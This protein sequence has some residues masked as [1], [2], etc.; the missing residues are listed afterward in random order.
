MLKP[1][2][3]KH[4]T[5]IR[6]LACVVVVL[7]V[8]SLQASPALAQPLQKIVAMVGARSG[9]SWP[10]WLAKDG[11]YYRKH[12]LDVELVF[13][14]HPAPMAAVISGQAVMTST[15]ADLAILAASKDP[16]LTLNGSFLNRG[17]FAM[18]AAKNVT[19]MEQLA[20]KK[21]GVGRVGDPPYH[22]TVSLLEKFGVSGR[23]IHW[24]SVGAD[25]ATRAAALQGG[26]IDAALVTA[27]SYFRLEAAGYPVLALISDYEDIYVSTY[28]LFRKDQVINSPKIAEGFIKAHAEAIK[29]FYDDRAFA[30]QT[31]LKYGG[32]RDQQDGNKVYDLFS[33]SRSFEPVPYILKD[34]VRAAVERQSQVLPQL[35]QFDFTKVIDNSIV[36]R[37]VREGFF[38]QVFGP[39]VREL[40][41]K[42]QAQAF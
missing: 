5:S 33:K 19:R 17:T 8:F 15:G 42:R 14:V 13:A 25:A 18:V 24:V 39:S 23:D 31:F 3:A 35:K 26:Q 12:G 32:A 29:R 16:S 9:A 7:T 36:D 11:G 6:F 38:Q 20:G 1:M 30:I 41:Q 21:V 27:P 40:Q 37:L 10:L 4:Q 34:S 28:Y 2:T 22:M